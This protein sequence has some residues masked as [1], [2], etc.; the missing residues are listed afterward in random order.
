VIESIPSLEDGWRS[1]PQSRIGIDVVI[2]VLNEAHVLERSII[3]VHDFLS[4]CVPYRWRIVIAENG[5]TDGTAEVAKRLCERF[6]RV[7]LLV[8]GKRGRGRALRA[9]W[10]RGDADILCYTDVDLSTELEAFPRLFAALI[11]GQYD[12]AVGSRLA[13]GARTTRSVK[14]DLI[15]RAYNLILRLALDV[16]F[17]DAQTGF[18]AITREVA[19]DVMPLVEDDGWFL[20]TELLVLSEKMGYRIADIPV[21]WIEDD[22]SRVKIIRTA[23]EDLK[24][25][26]RL[27]KLARAGAL[28]TAASVQSRVARLTPAQ[29]D[30]SLLPLV[31]SRADVGTRKS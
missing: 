31:E 19:R 6:E 10:M 16:R 3:T 8:I 13:R 26:N 2:P 21:R 30:S 15:S 20:D 14:R 9:A 27:R 28:R 25:V 24:G 7:E 11:E 5:S 17:S 1:K 12:L 4:R 22:D 29:S 18:K 23:W